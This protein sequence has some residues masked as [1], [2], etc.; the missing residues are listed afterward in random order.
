MKG[1]KRKII[2]ESQGQGQ[3]KINCKGE[4]GNLLWMMQMF[5]I[6]TGLLWMIQKFYIMTGVV[7]KDFMH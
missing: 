3:G 7:L 2:S 5:Y 6:M 1:K 4:V